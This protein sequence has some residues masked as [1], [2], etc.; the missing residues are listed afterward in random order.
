MSN[1]GHPGKR[2]VLIVLVRIEQLGVHCRL[3]SRAWGV[4]RSSILFTYAST[5]LVGFFEGAGHSIGKF[6]GFDSE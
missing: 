6:A 4:S 5:L 2:F 1:F 3:L